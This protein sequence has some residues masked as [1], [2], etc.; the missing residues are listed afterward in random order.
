M[1][2]NNIFE[3]V[4][5]NTNLKSDIVRLQSI[6]FKEKCLEYGNYKDYTIADYI[7]DK[8]FYQW[9][10]RHHCVDLNDFLNTMMFSETYKNAKELDAKSIVI[11]L[12]L[13]YNLWNLAQIQLLNHNNVKW[14]GNFYLVETILKDCLSQINHS[15]YFY[16]EY[17]MV[18]IIEDKPEITAVAEIADDDLALEI[19]KYNHHTLK[20]DIESKKSILLKL[21]SELEPKRKDIKSI[22]K[23][24]ED[25][26]FY[27]LN[28]LNLRHNNRSKKD[29]NYKEYIAKMRKAKLEEWYDE[30]YQEMLLAFLLLDDKDRQ[31]RI[32]ELRDKINNSTQK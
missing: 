28:N 25:N 26:I 22:N 21:G 1:K 5:N 14:F 4:K 6:I 7:D 24:L 10:Q 20:G 32:S 16:D 30:L 13:Y 15:A 31:T 11:V 19:I 3:I 27:M 17:E 2:R 18:L 12:E 23:E 9:E 29:K 8:L